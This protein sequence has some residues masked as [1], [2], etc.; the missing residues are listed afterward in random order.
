MAYFSHTFL[1]ANSTALLTIYFHMHS[2]R[3]RT[4]AL[5]SCKLGGKEQKK[6]RVT[7][8]L[9][10]CRGDRVWNERFREEFEE[11]LEG[12]GDGRLTQ[13]QS[14]NVHVDICTVI[15][16]GGEGGRGELIVVHE[17]DT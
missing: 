13:S 15:G 11:G 12:A 2:Q 10:N 14:C 3:E 9:E 17:I 8:H 6:K 16:R 7:I 5:C 1:R 4:L